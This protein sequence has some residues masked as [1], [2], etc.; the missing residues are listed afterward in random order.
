MQPQHR[1]NVVFDLTLGDK[2][3]TERAFAEAA[4]IASLTLVN[5]R[6]VANYLDTRGVV[7]DYDAADERLPLTRLRDL[8][9]GAT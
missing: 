2:A 7:A 4:K 5:Q 3:A 9:Q 6:L 1:D 8:Y